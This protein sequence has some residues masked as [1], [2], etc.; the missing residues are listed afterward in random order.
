MEEKTIYVMVKLKLKSEDEITEEVFDEVI[1]ELDYK[2]KSKTT[3]VQIE[4]TEIMDSFFKE[5]PTML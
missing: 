5:C 4:D 3:G 2:F 1:Q